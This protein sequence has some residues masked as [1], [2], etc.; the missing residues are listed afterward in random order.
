MD[1]YQIV[2]MT[3]EEI[4]TFKRGVTGEAEYTNRIS[5]GF[6]LRL[7]LQRKKVGDRHDILFEIQHLEQGIATSTKPATQFKYPPLKPFWH[8]HFFSPKHLL[9]N[10]G[11]RWNVSRGS[12]NRD[13]D[14]MINRVAE[15][16]G[17]DPDLWPKL[18][19]HQFMMGAL[20]E[21]SAAQRMTGDWIVFAKHEGQ[22]YYLDLAT[23]EEGEPGD[24]ANRLFEKLKQGSSVEFP[25]LFER[26]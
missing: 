24:C 26:E 5:L 1:D 21:R 18:L 17:H 22:N 12:G 16:P 14:A 8:K 9:R 20:E 13:L 7:M 15:E 2:S 6:A 4:A 25:F 11:E 3:F 10:V 19:A 23:H